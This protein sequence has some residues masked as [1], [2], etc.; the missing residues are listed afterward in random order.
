MTAASDMRDPFRHNFELP[1][2][3]RAIRDEC[4]HPNGALGELPIAAVEQSI[5]EQ[6]E[7]SAQ[8]YG[9]RIALSGP[10]Y[11]RL[12][13]A[14][15]FEQITNLVAALNDLGIGRGDHVDVFGSIRTCGSELVPE[16][17]LE[18][19]RGLT[20]PDFESFKCSLN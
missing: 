12:T 1:P 16:E 13:H 18:P 19:S 10:S 8:Q 11:D 4:F 7:M 6:F 17:R 5:P 3:Q 9:E 2:Q 14:R 20:P 15:V